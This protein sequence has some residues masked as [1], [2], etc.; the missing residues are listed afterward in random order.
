MV[1][2]KAKGHF[3][4]IKTLTEVKLESKLAKY[5]IQGW[6]TLSFEENLN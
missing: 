2:N 5:A 3:L 4:E 1:K 6:K